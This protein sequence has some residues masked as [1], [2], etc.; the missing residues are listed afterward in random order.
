M[1]SPQSGW[2]WKEVETPGK[3]EL[4]VSAGGLVAETL[5]QIE[6]ISSGAVQKIAETSK[7]V[8]DQTVLVAS[9]IRD[10]LKGFN[11]ELRQRVGSTVASIW[12]KA[13]SPVLAAIDVHVPTDADVLSF[14]LS[15]LNGGASDTLLVAIG[16]DVIAEIDLTAQTLVAGDRFD[17]WLGDH[18]GET[19]TLNFY[20]PSDAP[21]SAEFLISN[22]N[23]ISLN[24]PPIVQPVAAQSVDERTLLTFDVLGTDPDGDELTYSL[25]Q[26]APPGA[27]IDA[28]TG[29]FTWTP[30]EDQGPGVYEL[31]LF[32]T[33]NGPGNLSTAQ[34]ITIT[35]NEVND[36]PTNIALSTN[37][38]AENA[39]SAMIGTVTVT[40]PDANDTHTIVVS[41]SRFEVAAGQLKLKAGQSLNFEA[42][43]TINLDITATDAGGLGF[44]KTFTIAVTNVNEVPTNITLSATIVAE[45]AAG[46]T[47]GAV[48]VTDPDAN[49]TH[50]FVVSDNRFEIAAGQLKSKAGQSLNFEA[51]PTINLD[52]TATDAGGLAFTKSFTIAVTNVNEAPTNITLSATIVAENAAGATIGAVMVTDPDAND[53]HT[54][55]ISDNRFEIAAGQLKLKAGQSLN[56]EATPSISLDIAATDA[57]GLNF[58]KSFTITVTNINELPTNIVLSTNAVAENAAGAAIGAVTVTDPDANDTH[59][60]VVS[61]NRFEIAA[62]QLKLKAGQSLNFEATP[63]VSLDITP[64]DAGGLQFTK[65]FTI[66]VTNVNEVPTN[67]RLSA[68]TVAENVAGATIGTVTV[69]DPDANDTHTFIVSDSR[70]EIAAGQLKLKAGQSLNFETA[71]TINLDITA[72][73]AGGLAFTKSFTITVTNVN[74]A[75]TN[76]ALSATIVAENA[77]GA[78]IGAVTV[79]DPDANDTHTFVVSDNRFEIAAGQLQLKAGQSL[80]FEV[81][82]SVSL[83]ITATD[84]GGLELTRSFTITVTNVN[85]APTAISLT[86]AA[87]KE[88]T[89]GLVIGRLAVTDEDAGDTHTL[90]VLNDDFELDGD[91]LRLKEGRSLIYDENDPTIIVPV[92][93]V[94]SG[95]LSYTEQIA[96][97]V[98]PHPLPWRNDAIPTDANADGSVSPLDALVIINYINEHGPGRLP[99]PPPTTIVF[100][101]D[102]NGDG[103]V[104]PVDVLIV[105]NLL[106]ANS[107]SNEGKSPVPPVVVPAVPSI[108]SS[109]SIVDSIERTLT[110][111]TARADAFFS[112]LPGHSQ[113]YLQFADAGKRTT[114]TNDGDLEE[115]LDDLL[116]FKPLAATEDILAKWPVT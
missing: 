83:D 78:T 60:F 69:T 36:A 44:T 23:F 65:S 46:A 49:D 40:D 115:L 27:S 64:T 94:D 25:D 84:A 107:V 41:D 101:Y 4:V 66:T 53:T 76:I 92:T 59:T 61:D 52:I 68:S 38:V 3:F 20:M 74:E 111:D 70:F 102:T 114:D 88:N 37:T 32:V 7:S 21:S 112:S 54:F 17:L 31:V 24:K 34:F 45:N 86:N 51:T 10:S 73:D 42:T 109:T 29:R 91:V 104:S 56:F 22:L 110:S 13:H 58:T 89:P 28:V 35:V 72:T 105:I 81:T 96:I 71:P 116:A 90:T 113:E 82:P 67:I 19:I 103:S 93:A 8:W 48:T 77:A 33:D 63:S 14:D 87:A 97:V 16:S 99:V 108:D 11:T 43:P 39:A 12:A 79:T 1:P 2:I 95:G 15:V 50:T 9:D 75:P 47:I 57:G 80:D 26:G 5:R 106:N 6:S 55:V 18:A 100:Y 98:L 30:T 85:E 62:G